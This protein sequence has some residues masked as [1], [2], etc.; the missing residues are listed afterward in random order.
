MA[1][2]SINK[3]DT[4]VDELN[5]IKALILKQDM[6]SSIKTQI[7][8]ITETQVSLNFNIS[9]LVSYIK[10][11]EK[12]KEEKQNFIGN[13]IAD[14]L[15]R[16]HST[17]Q[18]YFRYLNPIPSNSE[19]IFEGDGEQLNIK[20]A[21]NKEFS[22]RPGGK[23]NAKNILSSGQLNVLAISIFLAINKEQQ[24][25]SLNF[26]GIDDPIQNMDDVNQ[27]TM[28]DVLNNIEKQLIIST[29]DINFLK[30]FIKKNEY[31]KN[32]I[33][34]YNLKSPYISSDKLET[35]EF[36]SQSAI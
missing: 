33:L 13:G 19:L 14:F 27:Y 1:L 25:H 34:V 8:N 17:V 29:H 20:V 21:Y 4:E 16:N 5:L 31:R 3:I 11:L 23:S 7:S 24:I 28:C 9:K 26:V 6:N 35:I 15:N 18:R 30:L 36:S 32:N 22:T 12:Y 10:L 2:E